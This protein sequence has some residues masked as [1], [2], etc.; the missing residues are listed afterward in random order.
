MSASERPNRNTCFL[1]FARVPALEDELTERVTECAAQLTQH[2]DAPAALGA[3]VALI[4]PHDLD[5]YDLALD[6]DAFVVVGRHSEAGVRAQGSASL[7]LRHVLL[8]PQRTT[9]A[10]ISIEVVALSPTVTPEPWP[11]MDRLPESL[12]ARCT[13]LLLGDA[14]LLVAAVGRDPDT[15]VVKI[16]PALEKVA[17]GNRNAAPVSS[18]Q[19]QDADPSR[20]SR[21]ISIRPANLSELAA[22]DA[23]DAQLWLR[24]EFGERRVTIGVREAWLNAGL[25]L[26]RAE[27]KNS[28]PALAAALGS[29]EVSRC[30]V[31]LRREGDVIAF[32]DTA[33]TWG[34]RVHG[35]PVR[36]VTIPAPTSA[37]GS[38]AFVHAVNPERVSLALTEHVFLTLLPAAASVAPD[39]S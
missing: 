10:D 34:L 26:G 28:H 9:E 23:P 4:G 3:R 12:A 31:F 37:F 18:S 27:G 17:C 21:L 30:H 33:S 24:V 14:L 5:L 7:S 36:R 13:A 1:P 32:Y 38:A 25:L 15:A 16:A 2:F 39:I 11:H 20:R 35:R 8:V 6:P 29:D 19:R 22:I